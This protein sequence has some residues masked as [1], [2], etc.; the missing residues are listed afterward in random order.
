M[1]ETLPWWH[2]AVLDRE[3]WQAIVQPTLERVQR[4]RDRDRLPH[5][6]LLIGPA[7]LGREL[8]AVETA[9][10]VV[11][12]GADEPWSEGGCVDRLRVGLHP[13]VEAALPT[14]AKKIIPIER[15]RHIVEAA[16]GRPFEGLRR[17]WIL[18]GVEA[19]CL[20]SASANAFLKVLEEPPPHVM[21]IL[22]AA[23]PMA[24]LPTI[25][26]RCQQLNL[27]GSVSVASAL[28]EAIDLPELTAGG[29]AEGAC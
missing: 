11:C 18:D 22:L 14:G 28:E 5:A 17:V 4:A 29:G 16:P 7:G 15:I 23:N 26:S 9:A 1:N 12:Q 2:E 20:P 24:V 21:F 3:S 13:D 6:L 8:A 10:L 27:P 25:R 19:R